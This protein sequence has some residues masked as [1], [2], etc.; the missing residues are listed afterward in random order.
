[1]WAWALA[2]PVTMKCHL[3]SLLQQTPMSP[4]CLPAA[5]AQMPQVP[6]LQTA[7]SGEA[8]TGAAF[9]LGW[10]LGDAGNGFISLSA[11]TVSPSGRAAL[12][13]H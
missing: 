2:V 11:S 13:S 5:T 1:M 12:N 3:T 4:L 10:S 7:V 9:D 8:Q 6:S